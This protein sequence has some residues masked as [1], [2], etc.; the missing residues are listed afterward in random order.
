MGS[1]FI[2]PAADHTGLGDAA[3]LAPDASTR[4]FLRQSAALGASLLLPSAALAQSATDPNLGTVRNASGQPIGVLFP[5]LG[6]PYRKVFEEIVAGIESQARQR[7]RAWPLAPALN[8]GELSAA[9]KRNN[10]RVVVALGR[11]GLKTAAALDPGMGLVVGGV[12]SVPD[13]ERHV[14]VCLTPDPALL[15]AQLKSLLPATRRVVVIYN[16]QHNEWLIKLAREAAQAASLELA[17]FEARD[18]ATAA[19]LFEASLAG[20]D[21]K[22]DAIWLP[23]D[24]TTVDETTIMPI[25]LR[26][27]WNR[28]IPV[29]SSSLLHVSKG[30][31]FSLYPNNTELGRTLGNLASSMLS[32]ESIPRG[33]TPLRDVHAALNTRTA[34]HIGIALDARMQRAFQTIY[35]P[36]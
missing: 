11:Q 23:I 16:P 28:S 29:F 25:V 27:S 13:G 36:V 21:R 4:R 33:V 22:R 19:R 5:D 31:L 12:S 15:F 2:R 24:P 35:P 20:A 18:L 17:V 14:G 1:A 9:L 3:P 7:V 30:V 32:G 26:E 34:S 10:T 8:V 6:E